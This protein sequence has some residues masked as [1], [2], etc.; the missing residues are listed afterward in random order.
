VRFY[1][2]QKIIRVHGMEEANSF[3]VKKLHLFGLHYFD[4]THD[5]SAYIKFKGRKGEPGTGLIALGL[6]QKPN[7]HGT[8]HILLPFEGSSTRR[9]HGGYNHFRLLALH[10][11]VVQDLFA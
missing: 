11:E 6:S 4:G 7:T 10:N 8:W 9:P 1:A 3:L 2:G 5:D